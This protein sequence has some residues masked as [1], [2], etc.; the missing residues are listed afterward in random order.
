VIL[1][2]RDPMKPAGVWPRWEVDDLLAM[3][4]AGRGLHMRKVVG[5]GGGLSLIETDLSN[6]A[7]P[8]FGKVIYKDLSDEATRRRHGK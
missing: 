7:E 3:P 4:E 1:D 8:S 2:V 6:P 5:A